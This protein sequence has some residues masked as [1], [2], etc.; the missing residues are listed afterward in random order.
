MSNILFMHN[1]SFA[2]NL[3]QTVPDN[4]IANSDVGKGTINLLNDLFKYL[5]FIAPSICSAYAVYAHIR[6]GISSEEVDQNKWKKTKNNSI[7]A[8]IGALIVT[9]I[10]KIALG[11]FIK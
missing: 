3:D 11:Y 6:M 7:Y 9:S 8:A 10:I 5:I 1:I 4:P 2:N